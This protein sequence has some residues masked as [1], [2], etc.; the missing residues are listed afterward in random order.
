[1]YEM[2]WSRRGKRKEVSLPERIKWIVK[3]R[4]VSENVCVCEWR[5]EG[6]E[7]REGA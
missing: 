3:E 2:R 5:R 4:N 6:W 7:G 1:M